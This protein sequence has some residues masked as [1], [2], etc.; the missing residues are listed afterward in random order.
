MKAKYLSLALLILSCQASAQVGCN[1]ESPHMSYG[2]RSDSPL[3]ENVIVFSKV[4]DGQV[5][6]LRVVGGAVG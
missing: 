6:D 2:T 5:Q 3:A 4:R 1:L